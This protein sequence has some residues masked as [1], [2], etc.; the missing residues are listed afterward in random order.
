MF[1]I[2]FVGRIETRPLLLPDDWDLGP[3]MLPDRE[4]S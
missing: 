1:G 2:S 3:P 4:K